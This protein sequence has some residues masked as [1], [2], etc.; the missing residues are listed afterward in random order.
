MTNANTAAPIVGATVTAG[1]GVTQT[2]STTTLTSGQYSLLLMANTYTVTAA[3]YGY[4]PAQLTGISVTSATTTTQNIVLTPASFYVVSGTVS[5]ARP[6]L[7]L[8]G[9]ITIAGYPSGRSTP[10]RP[11]ATTASPWQKAASILSAWPV[12][13]T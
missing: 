1:A 6:G 10:I 3:A 5:D 13:V 2:S 12:R 11:A 7:P 9:T 8:T 4:Q